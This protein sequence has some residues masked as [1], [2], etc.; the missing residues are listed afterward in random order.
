MATKRKKK[1]SSASKPKDFVGE[2]KALLAKDVEPSLMVALVA[3][4][5][6]F[7]TLWATKDIH[8]NLLEAQKTLKPAPSSSIPLTVKKT[9]GGGCVHTQ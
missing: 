3:I 5:I 8:Q 9:H 6:A 4:T 2:V 7:V 1:E